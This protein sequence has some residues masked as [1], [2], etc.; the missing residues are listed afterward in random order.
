[1][2]ERAETTRLERMADTRAGRALR[3]QHTWMQLAKFCA[4]GANG[5]IVKLS[6]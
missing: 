1:M 3:A 2:A 6:V 4:V 5:Y